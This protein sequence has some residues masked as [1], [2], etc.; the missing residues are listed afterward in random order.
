M[1]RIDDALN[2]LARQDEEKAR[3]I[4]MRFFGG[5]TAEEI[6]MCAN[7]PVN[8]VRRELRITQAWLHKELSA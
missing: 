7:V 6:S 3:L 8:K 5:M 2:A 4:E 1:I